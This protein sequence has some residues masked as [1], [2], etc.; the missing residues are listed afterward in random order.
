VKRAPATGKAAK[1]V[2]NK[3]GEAKGVP[4][5]GRKAKGVPNTGRKAEGVPNT[6][7]AA[8][9]AAHWNAGV[10]QTPQELLLALQQDISSR[11][12]WSFEGRGRQGCFSKRP[13][14]C[15]LVPMTEYQPQMRKAITSSEASTDT[16][17]AWSP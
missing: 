10:M 5:T 4:N 16:E 15:A 9:G 17:E 6:G 2:P 1:G 8:K 7:K 14:R 13:R 3:G 12:C 11:S